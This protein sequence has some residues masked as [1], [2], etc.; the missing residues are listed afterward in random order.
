MNKCLHD[1]M[2][3]IIRQRILGLDGTNKKI[4]KLQTELT[5]SLAVEA[6]ESKMKGLQ[7][8]LEIL[9]RKT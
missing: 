1:L 4:D 9:E 6:L 8:E 3:L 2:L 7:E 5:N